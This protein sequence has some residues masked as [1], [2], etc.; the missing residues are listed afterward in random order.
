MANSNW[1]GPVQSQ[2]GFNVTKVG[3]NGYYIA[4]DADGSLKIG[5]GTTVGTNVGLVIDSSGN[6]SLAVSDLVVDSGL[7]KQE[8]NTGTLELVGGNATQTGGGIELYGGAHANARDIVMR[9]DALTVLQWDDSVSQFLV[10]NTTDGSN[11]VLNAASAGVGSIIHG[12]TTGSVVIAGGTPNTNGANFILRGGSH[13]SEANDFYLRAGAVNRI[14]WDNSAGDLTLSPSTSGSVDIQAGDSDHVVLNL[15]AA[16]SGTVRH[17]YSNNDDG[18]A[19]FEFNYVGST[20]SFNLAAASGGAGNNVFAVSRA[21]NTFQFGAAY[22]LGF[23]GATPVARPSAYTQTYST[24]DKTVANP[25]AA[26]LTDSTGGTADQTLAAISGSGADADINN[27]FAELADEVNKLVAD[28]L[29]LR[30]GLT[31]VI[32]DLQSLGLLQ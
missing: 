32:D 12:Q 19:Y 22:S 31:A 18:L 17:H 27:N 21:S 4:E 23:F 5:A 3:S 2:N 26:T 24:A 25:T 6:V 9:A 29:D 11:I 15:R 7:I 30:Q 14:A 8:N 10:G 13:A 16:S 28:N 20:N 1:T